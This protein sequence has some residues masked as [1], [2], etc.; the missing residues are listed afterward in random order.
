MKV[1]K[2][3]HD[4]IMGEVKPYIRKRHRELSICIVEQGF[5]IYVIEDILKEQVK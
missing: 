3:I 2:K 4:I 5:H 1:D